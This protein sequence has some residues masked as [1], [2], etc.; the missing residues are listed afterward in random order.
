MSKTLTIIHHAEADVF[1]RRMKVQGYEK[2][3]QASHT[4]DKYLA[5]AAEEKAIF[6]PMPQI[7]R[8]T[9]IA[10]GYTEAEMMIKPW[11][12]LEEFSFM[13]GD[14]GFACEQV[15]MRQGNGVVSSTYSS[16]SFV[17]HGLI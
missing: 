9:I 6:C 1:T 11:L 2:C 10:M 4:L 12:C 16:H 13:Y 5:K 17:K 3:V 8:A 15:S 14:F 7:C